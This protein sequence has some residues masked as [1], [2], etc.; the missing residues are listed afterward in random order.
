[1]IG[2]AGIE[3]RPKL[4]GQFSVFGFTV[5][6]PIL[7]GLESFAFLLYLFILS[8]PLLGTIM[9]DFVKGLFG[10]AK[11]AVSSVVSSEPDGMD[12]IGLGS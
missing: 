11:S 2:P 9:A 8:L 12:S 3:P 4:S 1:M 5:H 10:G 7:L 6:L